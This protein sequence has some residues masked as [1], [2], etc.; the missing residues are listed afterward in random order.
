[1]LEPSVHI[2]T[3]LCVKMT[4]SVAGWIDYRRGF[5][6][7]HD[8]NRNV[9]AAHL[10]IRQTQF[11]FRTVAESTQYTSMELRTRIARRNLLVQQQKARR[12]KPDDCGRSSCSCWRSLCSCRQPRAVCD[13]VSQRQATNR[14]VAVEWPRYWPTDRPVALTA[15]R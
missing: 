2:H 3:L 13:G 14:S 6:S 5:N 11:F 4:L 12:S 7:C 1:M 9:R 15:A 8:V 10:D